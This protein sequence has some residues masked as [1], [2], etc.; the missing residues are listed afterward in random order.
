[1]VYTLFINNISTTILLAVLILISLLILIRLIPKTRQTTNNT[2]CKTENKQDDAQSTQKHATDIFKS[3]IGDTNIGLLTFD[4]TLTLTSINT[5]FSTITG[6]TK[7]KL[8]TQ[9]G[10]SLPDIL[11]NIEVTP[12]VKRLVEEHKPFETVVNITNTQGQII[13]MHLTGIPIYKPDKTL[14]AYTL[15]TI[16]VSNVKHAILDQNEI[17]MQC[18]SCSNKLSEIELAFK[19]SS[20]HHIQLQ[21][22]LN[23]NEEQRL[24]LQKAFNLINSQKES[25]EKANAEIKE[26]SRL[27]ELFLS[28]TSHEIRTPLNSIIGFTNLLLKEEL[29]DKQISYLKNIKESSDN[30]LVVLNDILDISKIEAGKMT[31]EK[32]SFSLH[33]LIDYLKRTLEFKIN[34]KKY[35]FK[36]TI[37]PAI[38]AVIV[39]DPVRLNQIL[40]NLLSNAI[41]FTDE[42]G[43]IEFTAKLKKH[44]QNN[45]DLEFIIADNGI[46][47]TEEQQ[48]NVF[49]AFTQADS[50]TTRKFGGTGLGL[51]IVK[52][53][54]ELQDGQITL[55]S[56]INKGSTF[57]FFIPFGIG[58]KAVNKRNESEEP[59][60]P[61]NDAEKIKILL[62]EDNKINQQLAT[63]T[64][65]T[66]NNK[67][68]IDI[69]ENG[70]EAIKLLAKN[71]YSMIFM[72]IQMPLLN[73]KETT[74]KIRQG[75]V[76]G[77]NNI[78]IIAMTAH[79]LKDE[80]EKCM[81]IGMNDYLTKPFIPNDLFRKIKFYGKQ[82]VQEQVKAGQFV[83]YS[84]HDSINTSYSIAE[85]QQTVNFKNFNIGMLNKIY[86]GNA[87]QLEKI[88]RMYYET[89]GEEIIDMRNSY[90][91]GDFQKTQNRAHALKPKM[92]YLGRND[93]H[94]LAKNVE[95]S[96]K[97]NNF[98]HLK[99]FDWI[100]TIC[101][102]WIEIENELANFLDKKNKENT[103]V[104]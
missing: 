79:A 71:D 4:S 32:V 69:A 67:I 92:A 24:E 48:Q 101:D 29:A 59:T 31:F 12:E 47:M 46:G 74:I 89:V 23:K 27:K 18:H 98:D 84:A 21:K 36:I 55:E 17:I 49:N 30:L 19:K 81:A 8:Q 62:A 96:I 52:N 85:Q 6:Y 34:E 87:K 86:K 13:H 10:K 14:D 91:Q 70:E 35:N 60:I 15:L 38:P 45:I 33:E 80:R 72:D 104:L 1:M 77:K 93:I 22:A 5:S 65:K 28:N 58:T 41:K 39:G 9:M 26:Q 20:K 99:L 73:G 64:I 75:C 97:S 51:S 100:K 94:E 103:P 54:V 25:L 7:D 78:P 3:Y 88:L 66:W 102:E 82:Q 43:T 11:N 53:L 90:D 56:Q 63:D 37:D 68:S 44:N 57:T 95:I 42:L 2:P 40:L 83:Q 61:D 76:A 50:S 16:D